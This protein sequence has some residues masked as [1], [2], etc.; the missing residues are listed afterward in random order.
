MRPLRRLIQDAVEDHIAT[1]L[2]QE[3]YAKGDVI[4][5]GTKKDALIF[6]TLHE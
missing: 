3:T 6:A 4:S 5:I 1:E 2:L